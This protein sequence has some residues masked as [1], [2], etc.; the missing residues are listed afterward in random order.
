MEP[1]FDEPL[2][3]VPRRIHEG[4]FV[5]LKCRVSGHPQPFVLFFHNECLLS[6]VD[7]GDGPAVGQRRPRICELGTCWV[8]YL[9]ILKHVLI[10]FIS[11]HSKYLFE[12]YHICITLS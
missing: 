12:N 7:N 11:L 10:D 8:V 2:A 9:G 6:T 1:A 4:D 3:S 5:L